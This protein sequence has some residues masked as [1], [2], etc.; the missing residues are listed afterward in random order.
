M[1]RRASRADV[2]CADCALIEAATEGKAATT[3][4]KAAATEGKAA[5]TEGKAAKTEG[6]AAA[7]EGK[8]A[9]T[10]LNLNPVSEGELACMRAGSARCLDR[11]HEARRRHCTP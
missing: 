4:G 10:G 9:A 1:C 7:T 3:E 8:A 6:K 2:G 11:W 5:A